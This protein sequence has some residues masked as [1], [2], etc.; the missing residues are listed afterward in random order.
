MSDDWD[1]GP[2]PPRKYARTGTIQ[3]RFT[4][5][6]RSA[7]FWFPNENVIIRAVTTIFKLHRWML[8]FHSRYFAT[9]FNAH[10]E[11]GAQENIDSCLVYGVSEGL[12]IRD[13]TRL[14]TG[15]EDPQ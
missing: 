12:V 2:Q 4:F 7:K 15:I 14:L 11:D 6:T 1:N 3:R 10:D 8:A 13:F 5:D 9:L